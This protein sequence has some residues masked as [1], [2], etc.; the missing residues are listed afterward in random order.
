MSG[1]ASVVLVEDSTLLREGLVRLLAEDGVRVLAALPDATTLDEQVERLRPDL[2]LLDIRLPPTHRDEGVRAA[3]GLR[4]SH[5]SVGVLLLSQ[6]VEST[7]ATELLATG[8]SGVGY[9]LK[10]RVTD[11][12]QLHDAVETIAAGGTVLDPLL[13]EHLLRARTAP[14]AR[15]TPREREVLQLMAEGR[16]NTAIAARLVVTPGA[17]EKHVTSIL[18]KLDL[19]ASPDAHRR[20]LAVLR[21]L[22]V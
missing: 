5:P 8:T 16:S 3:I 6:Y 21:F 14:L 2:V 19:E 20:V 18:T 10:D 7:Y 13:V 1:S 9:L 22:D 15:L 11:L 12:A 4:R 17:V